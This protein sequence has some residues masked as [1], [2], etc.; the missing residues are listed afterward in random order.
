MSG[1]VLSD[2]PWHRFAPSRADRRTIALAKA[3]CLVEYNGGEY[4]RY[5][6]EVFAGDAALIEAA[7]A[8]GDDER[9]HGQAL[10]LWCGLADPQ[11]DFA[12]AFSRFT[13]RIRL[14]RQVTAS[15]RGSRTGELVA[16][17]A[18]ECGT[19][20]YYSCL[21]DAIE[22][23]VL[24]GICARIA[25]DEFR[26]YRMFHDFGRIWQRRERIGRLRKLL[27]LL[28]RL[29]EGEDDELAYAWHC[30]NGSG[31]YRRRH[32]QGLWLRMS[33]PML[34]DQHLERCVGMLARAA[35]W[36]DEDARLGWLGRLLA[37]TI[38]MR[39]RWLA[40]A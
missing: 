11:W 23:P 28:G 12:T 9:R 29:G 6:T 10:R 31:E 8:W 25:S 14:P 2:I 16:R 3:A 33:E 13:A 7:G 39:I 19:S 18:V 1:W 4:A 22:E 32:D 26:H 36:S 15:V 17:C 24:K 21:R 37:T 27:T 5:L 20:F 34:R 40:A 35:G 30:A 38:R